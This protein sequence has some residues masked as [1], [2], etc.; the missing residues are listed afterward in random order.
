MS[1]LWNKTIESATQSNTPKNHD[2][3]TSIMYQTRRHSGLIN[4]F[5]S[6]HDALNDAKDLTVWKISF[7]LPT[8][9]RIRLIREGDF[10]EFPGHWIYSPIINEDENDFNTSITSTS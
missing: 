8:G 3:N 6:F 5:N 1:I 4:Q 2:S 9:E 10:E 7:T